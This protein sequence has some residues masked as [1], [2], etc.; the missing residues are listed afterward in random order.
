MVLGAQ[1]EDNEFTGLEFQP[2]L[3]ASWRPGG[4]YS[5]WGA[6]T[7]SVR[8]PSLEE[9]SLDQNSAF[10]G[11]P[12]FQ[13][14][15]VVSYEIGLRKLFGE[16]ASFDVA[17][18]YNEYDDLHNQ[19]L[20]PFTFQQLIGNQAEGEAWGVELAG[21][22]KPSDRWSLRTAYTVFQGEYRSKVDGSELGTDEYHPQHQINL[23][24]YYDL[25]EDWELDLG[26]YLVDGIGADF[27]IANRFRADARLGWNPSP[28]LQCFIGAQQFNEDSQSEFDVFD[29]VH[30]QVI[31]GLSWMPGAGD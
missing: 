20:D 26:F 7:R 4:T 31:F 6:I 3:R 23:R 14:E 9:V 5:A 15:T 10:V 1:V 19:E 27:D 16:F 8:T 22:F 13:S 30:R 18:F 21:D 11:N 28:E 24:S 17:A 2:T 12:D 25:G 29:N